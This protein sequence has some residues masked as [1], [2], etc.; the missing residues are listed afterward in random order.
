MGDQIYGYQVVD[1]HKVGDEVEKHNP[2]LVGGQNMGFGS[3]DCGLWQAG[4]ARQ[5]WEKGPEAI[6][7]YNNNPNVINGLDHVR[8]STISQPLKSYAPEQLWIGSGHAP[9]SKHMRQLPF[10]V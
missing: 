8:A 4:Y 1:V 2:M 10:F 6:S 5:A 3:Y 9:G 7:E